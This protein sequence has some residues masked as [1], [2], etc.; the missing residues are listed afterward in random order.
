MSKKSAHRLER[1]R[2]VM[3][4]HLNRRGEPVT[5]LTLESEADNYQPVSPQ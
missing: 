5:D 2:H 1:V 4:R 3:G